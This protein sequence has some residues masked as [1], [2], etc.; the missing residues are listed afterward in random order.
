MKDGHEMTYYADTKLVVNFARLH[1][2]SQH[3]QSAL[4]TVHTQLAQLERDAQPLVQAWGGEAKLAYEQRQ[5]TWRRA[6]AELASLLGQIKRALDESIADY[7]ATERHNA[8]LF[9]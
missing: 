4:S 8:S 2:V 6:A 3:I 9:E 1:E 5:D 7:Q